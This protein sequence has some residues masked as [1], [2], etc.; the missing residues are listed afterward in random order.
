MRKLFG[1]DGIRGKANTY[2]IT[3]EMALMV[4]KAAAIVLRNK[5]KKP[6]FLIGKDPRLSGYMLEYA[7]TSGICSTGADVLLVGPMPT[8]AIA[9]IT[10]SFG[11]DAGIMISASHNPATDN[12]I[13]LFDATGFKLPDAVE[14]EIEKLIFKEDLSEYNVPTEQIGRAYRIDDA[15]G[16]YI[17]F[18]K[19]SINNNSLKGIK[20]AL[21]CANGASYKVSPMIF[22]ELGA[23]LVVIN[24]EPDGLNINKN[25]G[26]LHPEIVK[27]VVLENKADIGIS[28]DG[29]ADRVIIVDEKGNILD[30]DH[31]LSIAAIELKKKN[32]LAKDTVVVTHYTNLAFDD[33]MK[34]HKI[35]VVRVDNGDRYVLEEMRKKGFNLG[36]EQSG[37][38]IFSDYNSTGDG[39]ISALQIVNILKGSKKKMSELALLLVKYPQIIV[40]VNVNEKKDIEKTLLIKK[41]IISAEKILGKYG[42]HLIRYSGTQNLLRIMIE[43]K[44]KKII[45][46]L[47][48]KIADAAK[49]EL[50]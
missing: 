16:R 49:R 25:S 40:N 42:R 37:H 5:I 35:N 1:T 36:G 23:D 38:I 47:A 31:L 50:R 41:E 2:P 44:D 6:K 11:A 46:E 45:T 18:A 15:K 32:K 7:L 3:A 39:T 26:A 29:D 14:E 13:K 28:L 30:G 22:S 21:D 34:K 17:E 4:G 8:P 12:G 20:I 27:V 48:N 9:H 24:A 10:R 33:L 19:A 43:G